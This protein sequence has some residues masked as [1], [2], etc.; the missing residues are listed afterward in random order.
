MNY[1]TYLQECCTGC[2]LCHSVAGTKLKTDDMGFVRPEN[3]QEGGILESLCPTYLYMDGVHKFSIWGEYKSVFEGY[4]SDENVRY[5]ASSGGALTEIS[6]YLLENCIVDG[7][8]H[9]GVSDTDPMG[10]QTFVSTSADDVKAHMGSRYSVS[11]PLADIMQVLE[12][13]KT[14]AF[15]GK[16]CD[17]AALK[18][19]RETNQTLSDQII[20]TLSF[21]CAGVPSSRINEKLLSQMGTSKDR[22]K[23]FQYRGNGW[24]GYATAIDIDGTTHQ[25]SYQEAW[26]KY[27]GRDV[28]KICRYCMDGI[29]EFADIS[30]AD[31]WYLKN[32]NPD[33]SEHPGRNIIF[34]RNEK[35]IEIVNK[36]CEAGYLFIKDCSEVMPEFEK[37]QPYHYSRRV[38]MKYRLLALR[39]FFRFAPRYDR[40]LLREANTYSTKE[41]NWSIFKGTVKR[42]FQGK[43]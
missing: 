19:Y 5:R 36:A 23:S 13:G 6:I 29:G 15:I 30:C 41:M 40:A 22:V 18:R 2:G 1:E 16:P 3:T 27:L 4:S 28:N 14:Y 21:F 11:S 20:L 35:G 9:T 25:M 12:Q 42:I 33:F 32:D 34:C 26:S 7:I 37:Y 17:V 8:I 43:L 24:P 38:T 10:T 31:L 39:M